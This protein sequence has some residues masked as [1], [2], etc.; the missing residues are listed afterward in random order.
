VGRLL[1]AHKLLA[2]ASSLLVVAAMLV[3]TLVSQSA[4]RPV[5][6]GGALLSSGS[7]SGSQLHAYSFRMLQGPG[8]S[9]WSMYLGNPAR[10]G[11]NGAESTITPANVS[12]LSKTWTATGTNG[13]TDQP[14]VV[15][16]QV[17]WGSWD[18][19]MH[20]TNATTGAQV[21]KTKLGVTTDSSCAPT[22]AG[23]NSSAAYGAVNGTPAVFVGGGG[24]D[25][26][27]GGHVYMYALNASTGAIIWKAVIGSSPSD[28]PWSSPVIS[29]GSIYYGISSFGDCP[30]TRGRVVKVDEATGAL[31]N[32]FY[33]TK[34]GCVG[35]GVTSSPAIDANGKLYFDTGNPGNCS[36]QSGDYSESIVELNASNLSFVASWSVPSSQRVSDSDFLAT[37]TIFTGT[38]NG[39]PTEMVGAINKNAYYYALNAGKIASGPIWEDHLGPGGDCPQCGTA[40]IAPSAWDGRTLYI[41]GPAGTINGTSCKGSLQAVNPATGSY[42]WR[43]CLHSSPLGAVMASPGLLFVNHGQK[44]SAYN[45]GTGAELFV[46]QDTNS[47]SNFWGAATVADGWLY[48]GNLDGT[49]YAFHGPGGG[50]TVQLSN[51]VVKDTANAGAWSLATGLATGQAQY[52]DR[53]YT[54]VS[55]PSQLVGA[56]WVRTANNSKTFTGDPTCTFTISQQATVY[57]AED[58]R[59]PKPSWMDSSWTN[60]GLMLTDNQVSGKNTFVLY[61]KTFPAGMVSLGP[62]DNGAN[63]NMYTVIA[64]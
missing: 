62:A 31:Q 43:D 4:P 33:T 53:G 5:F 3:T 54:L 26:T 12:G 49:L 50:T 63:D 15:N 8:D 41:E 55:V 27:G 42:L 7:V 18:G 47:A 57:V 28:F 59:L 36:G 22:T 52:G 39:T 32:T 44:V 30:L 56:A 51:L 29:N 64:Q 35:D 48:D 16:G 14:V 61:Q 23:I 46:Y 11:F 17:Y 40:G 20:D 2:L 24:N 10:T 60:S 25:S 34:S 21:W 9:D 45:A 13:I 1:L 19:F 6:I 37:P 38:I 58:T